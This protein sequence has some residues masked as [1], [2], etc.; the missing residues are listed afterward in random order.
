M[1][2]NVKCQP[3]TR[4]LTLKVLA[5]MTPLAF[6]LPV[7]PP[8]ANQGKELQCSFPIPSPGSVLSSV[9]THTHTHIHV[10]HTHTHT[11][12]Q[13]HTLPFIYAHAYTYHTHACNHTH[14]HM[15]IHIHTYVHVHTLHPA[16]RPLA[17]TPFPA[18]TCPMGYTLRTA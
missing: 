13:L 5:L 18:L 4:E 15:H 6:L 10:I 3:S 1:R 14:M 12:N 9:H 16:P 2:T 8:A 7:L 17:Y 11:C